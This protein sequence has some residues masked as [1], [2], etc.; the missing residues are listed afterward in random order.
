MSSYC[1]KRASM[2]VL[3]LFLVLTKAKC[4]VILIIEHII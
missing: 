2:Q 3:A 1:L 4:S